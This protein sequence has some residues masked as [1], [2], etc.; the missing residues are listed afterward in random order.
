VY[1]GTE[2]SKELLDQ[3]GKYKMGKSCIYIKSL[4]D[5]Q[6]EVLEELCME[7]IAFLKKTYVVE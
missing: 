7:T 6:L 1:S 4:K 2:R 3:L 5:I